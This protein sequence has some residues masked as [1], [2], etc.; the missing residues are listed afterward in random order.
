MAI[1]LH[2]LHKYNDYKIEISTLYNKKSSKI[3]LKKLGL[4][5]TTTTKTLNPKDQQGPARRSTNNN[6][7]KANKRT[8]NNKEHINKG[9]NS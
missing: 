7:N 6:S 2:I 4:P 9:T 8:T 1:D 3:S 5:I